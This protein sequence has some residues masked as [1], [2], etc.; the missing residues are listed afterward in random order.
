MPHGELRDWK[1]W[2]PIFLA[3]MP[4]ISS[5]LSWSSTPIP[6]LCLFCCISF[7]F[8]FCVSSLISLLCF[9]IPVLFAAVLPVPFLSCHMPYTDDACTTCGTYTAGWPPLLEFLV[10]Q[11]RVLVLGCVS[12]LNTASVALKE[13][14]QVWE[15]P[16]QRE[17]VVTN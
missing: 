12:P 13:V 11:A 1:Q 4:Q 9:L 16:W 14:E 6:F 5:V 8:L 7:C 3:A 15:F 17:Y 10:L 2:K